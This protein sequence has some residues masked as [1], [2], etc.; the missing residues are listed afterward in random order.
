MTKAMI[1]AMTS[2]VM[3]IRLL[4]DGSRNRMRQTIEA[5][6]HQFGTRAV[7][8]AQTRVFEAERDGLVGF[9]VFCAQEEAGE[10]EVVHVRDALR[11]EGVLAGF[12]ARECPVELGGA[13]GLAVRVEGEDGIIDWLEM[14]LFG[15]VRFDP[16]EGGAGVLE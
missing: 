11:G 4:D 12:G 3:V 16:A 2:C 6:S 13:Q 10:V 9:E 8:F 7:D 5:T 15:C 14:G 1:P